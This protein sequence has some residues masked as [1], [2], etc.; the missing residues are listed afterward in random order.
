[1][2]AHAQRHQSL[3]WIECSQI[4]N[5][6]FLLCRPHTLLNNSFAF[7]RLVINQGGYLSH[8]LIN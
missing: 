6:I 1:M 8:W 5:I 2:V 7:K 3:E 4:F